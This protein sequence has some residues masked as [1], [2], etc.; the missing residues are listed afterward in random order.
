MA[1]LSLQQGREASLQMDFL[2]SREIYFWEGKV[3]RGL[4]GVLP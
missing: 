4:V 3:K 2:S 1:L